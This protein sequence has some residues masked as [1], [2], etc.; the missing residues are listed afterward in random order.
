MC[1]CHVYKF[2]DGSNEWT[3]RFVSKPFIQYGIQWEI[4][5]YVRCA[6]K[7]ITHS[8][9]TTTKISLKLLSGTIMCD[10]KL[11]PSAIALVDRA[12]TLRETH[13]ITQVL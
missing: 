2:K 8:P 1:D 12:R 7:Q 6:S 10:D 9:M 4:Y 5:C 11:R 3:C 13:K